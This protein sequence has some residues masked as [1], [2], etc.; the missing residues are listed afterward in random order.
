M[1]EHFPQGRI[2]VHIFCASESK[3]IVHYLIFK[4]IDVAN[5]NPSNSWSTSLILGIGQGVHT[6]LLLTSL[7]LVKKRTWLFSF[8]IIKAG[9]PHSEFGCGFRTPNLTKRSTS[10]LEYR[11]VRV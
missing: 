7:K 3:Q 6:I 1:Q 2:I 8:A 9:E 4:S 11:F 10:F 5:V